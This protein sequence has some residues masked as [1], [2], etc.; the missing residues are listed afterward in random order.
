MRRRNQCD[1]NSWKNFNSVRFDSFRF[2]SF[3]LGSI[4]VFYSFLLHLSLR[5]CRCVST[6]F[7]SSPFLSFSFPGMNS[8]TMRKQPLHN[9]GKPFTVMLD[10][11]LMWSIILLDQIY[12]DVLGLCLTWF[13][14]LWTLTCM[15]VCTLDFRVQSTKKGRDLVGLAGSSL[16]FVCPNVFEGQESTTARQSSE[17]VLEI[18]RRLLIS[19][20][21]VCPLG[22][23]FFANQ[24]RD[25]SGQACWAFVIDLR[26][27]LTNSQYA[28]PD[29]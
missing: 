17:V 9:Q 26:T 23:L 19:D 13:C 1:G 21:L 24:G 29:L 27:F 20:S 10:S 28:R 4:H 14:G 12:R 7:V 18:K 8:I 5:F 3:R 11:S 6:R 2:I 25:W 16:P 22:H 15:I